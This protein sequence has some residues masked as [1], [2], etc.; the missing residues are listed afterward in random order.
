[1]DAECFGGVCQSQS[2]K[3]FQPGWRREAGVFPPSDPRRDR[4][5]LL[6]WPPHWHPFPVQSKRP[7]AG[8]GRKPPATIQSSL[9]DGKGGCGCWLGN[10]GLF[11]GVAL[12][13][14]EM[15]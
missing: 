10:Q 2:P 14:S 15:A 12:E 13:L 11:E 5:A 9:R 7:R 8:G 4:L 6:Q 1:M 3:D